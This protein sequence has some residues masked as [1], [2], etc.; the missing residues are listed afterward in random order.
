MI[1]NNFWFICIFLRLSIAFF[2]KYN[3]NN[4]IDKIM[5]ILLM[6]KGLGFM[7]KGLTGSNNEIQLS[8]V[9][10]HE[11]RYIHGIN[12]ILASYYLYKKN[13]NMNFCIL[14]IDICFSFIYRIITNQ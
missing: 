11:T 14:L 9:F 6:F 8:K 1:I 2:I 13:K 4:F 3:L 7:Y 10:W 12:H 5:S